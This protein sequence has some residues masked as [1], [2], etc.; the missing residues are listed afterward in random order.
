MGIEVKRQEDFTTQDW[1]RY[2][3]LNQAILQES[4]PYRDMV[5]EEHFIRDPRPLFMMNSGLRC[6]VLSRQGRMIALSHYRLDSDHSVCTAEV[7]FLKDD[8]DRE[9]SEVMVRALLAIRDEHHLQLLQ[10]IVENTQIRE[11]YQN[12]GHFQKVG[13]VRES[14]L[15]LHQLDLNLMAS[16]QRTNQGF[17]LKPLAWADPHDVA[18]LVEAYNE[19]NADVPYQDAVGMVRTREAS[20]FLDWVAR[21]QANDLTIPAFGLYF[22][23]RMAGLALFEIRA[24]DPKTAT[25]T[26]TGIARAFRKRG[27][28]QH[29]KACSTLHLM[30]LYPSLRFI[31]TANE[32]T[33]QPMLKINTAMGFTVKSEFTM[34][35]YQGC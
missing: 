8:F 25:I 24:Y 28:G 1:L 11:H 15:D 12:S 22:Q 4:Y 34:L 31:V 18:A 21:L 13:Q 30:G 10:M 32:E 16:W 14:V 27:L 7:K 9:S 23:D 19:S 6:L 35:R 2:Y 17:T 5:S 20:Y 29:L 3:R 26:Y 33:N